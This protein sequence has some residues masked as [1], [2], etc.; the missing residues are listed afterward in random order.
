[1]MDLQTVNRQISDNDING[2]VSQFDQNWRERSEVKYN[3]WVRGCP[4][5]QIQL[6]FRK[7]WEVFS[8]LLG[9]VCNG[10]CLEV[11][12]GRGS[13]SSYFADKGFDCVLLDSSEAVLKTAEDIFKQ[14]GHVAEFIHGDALSLPF[15]PDSFD[16]VVSIGLL[17]HFEDVK[18][19]MEEQVRVLRP[20]GLFLGYVV[21]ERSKNIQS[22]FR[23]LNG[24]IKIF[25]GLAC[26]EKNKKEK[27]GKTTV[28]RSDYNSK[29]YLDALREQPVC[30][31][32][33]FGMYPLPMISHS[34]EFPFSLLPAPMEWLLTR[35][36]EVILSVSK[37]ITGKNPWICSEEMGQAFLLTFRK[38][39]V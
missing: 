15:D 24:M 22:Y 37:M 38:A 9:D 1:M 26:R 36:F 14:N 4:S 33:A 23:W 31:I 30:N 11:G 39:K 2:C 25:A 16:V 8:E 5:N 34:P 28:F 20:G 7:H 13:I 21:P 17:E 29:H 27:S 10:K 18:K 32:D 12:C 6:A 3:H 19:L 35:F